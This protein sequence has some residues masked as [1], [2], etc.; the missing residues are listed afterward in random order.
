MNEEHER[1][2]IEAQVKARGLEGFLTDCIS[3]LTNY[4]IPK[5]AW[6]ECITPLLD[7]ARHQ[8]KEVEALRQRVE[9]GREVVEAAIA[10][11]NHVEEYGYVALGT[12]AY[13]VMENA[14]Q[15]IARIA[16]EGVGEGE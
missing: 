10:V 15:A 16:Q 3:P 5:W 14:V 8:Q 4:R 2:D 12:G 6:V 9:R 1:V 7:L 11:V 13:E